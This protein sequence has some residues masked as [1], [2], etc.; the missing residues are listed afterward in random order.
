MFPQQ[1]RMKKFIS[2]HFK[3]LTPFLFLFPAVLGRL[4]ISHLRLQNE[5]LQVSII[6][7]S[8]EENKTPPTLLLD[9]LTDALVGVAGCLAR[10]DCKKTHIKN[11]KY[12]LKAIKE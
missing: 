2:K 4:C 11:N 10:N 8:L 7:S 5:P 6:P 9:L 12:I 1:I 3:I